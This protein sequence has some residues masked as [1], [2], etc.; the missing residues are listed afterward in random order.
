MNAHVK[1][2][3]S[4]R[5]RLLAETKALGE[6][7]A[8][9]DRGLTV[10]EATA[11]DARAERVAAIDKE[12]A[13]YDR[14]E[15]ASHVITGGEPVAA[16]K[17][18]DSLAA[19]MLDIV[20][21]E[22]NKTVSPRLHKIN[23]MGVASGLSTGVGADGGYL[24]QTDF[25][26]TLLERTYETG[27]FL[28]RVN[29]LPIGPNSNGIKIPAVD[30]TSRADGSRYGGLRAYWVEE[31]G[32]ITSSKPKFRNVELTLHKLAGLA[33]A[34]DEMLQD[35][36]LLAAYIQQRLP[37]EMAFTLENACFSGNGVGKPLGFR[38]S[39]AVVEVAIENSQTLASG[40]F[41]LANAA[42]MWAAMW[43][44]SRANAVWYI[45]TTVESQ[46][47]QMKVGDTPVMM[48]PGTGAT[49]SPYFTLFGR[50]VIPVEYCPAIGTVGDVMLVDPSAYTYIDKGGIQSAQSIHLRFLQEE[51]A[52]RFTIRC[53]G[54]PEWYT[55]LT[56]FDGVTTY[57]P[58]ITLGARS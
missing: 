54:Q 47:M 46:L 1:S 48:L 30:E 2:L 32:T 19:Q 45:S 16:S 6:T 10:E 42:K 57:S 58:F 38:N 21:A 49:Q 50:P 23:E 26:A 9:T 22:T 18:Y 13:R 14:I 17:P 41:V 27:A 33:Y 56:G 39:G 4:E 3:R 35:A 40:G 24:V 29:R 20:A 43:P 11:D 37:Q 7:L 31:A 52:F 28:S 12:L 36:P 34:T 15:R 53:D 55:T 8:A 25:A 51:T 44:R 5:A